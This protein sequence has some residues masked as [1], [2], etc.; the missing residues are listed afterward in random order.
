MIFIYDDMFRKLHFRNLNSFNNVK[1]ELG[2]KKQKE[3]I[4]L[5]IC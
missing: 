4:C 1:S 3:K 2:N 5:N